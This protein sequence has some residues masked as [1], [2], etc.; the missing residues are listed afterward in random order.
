[1]LGVEHINFFCQMDILG[2]E[3]FNFFCQMNVLGVGHLVLFVVQ[4]MTLEPLMMTACN[5][6]SEL[7][8][9]CVVYW[10]C[11]QCSLS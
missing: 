10:Y 11:T 5:I 7:Y 4:F 3:H 9:S 2:A 6:T 8:S 1:M